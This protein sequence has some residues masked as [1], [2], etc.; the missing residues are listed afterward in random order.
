[1]EDDP[2]AD[3]DWTRHVNRIRK[4]IFQ[5]MSLIITSR[6]LGASWINPKADGLTN[7]AAECSK[8]YLTVSIAK[9]RGFRTLSVGS[10]RLQPDGRGAGSFHNLIFIPWVGSLV[11]VPVVIVVGEGVQTPPDL[12]AVV[13]LSKRVSQ[14]EPVSDPHFFGYAKH[15]FRL[16]LDKRLTES[17]Q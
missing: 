17:D 12:R 6:L 7:P 1:M 13:F 3:G 16:S 4:R 5:A 14:A 8:H 10:E 2:L 9:T 11:Q 15:P